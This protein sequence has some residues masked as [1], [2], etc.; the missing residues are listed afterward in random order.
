MIKN[1]KVLIL[2]MAKSGYEVAKLI[3]KGNNEIIVVFFSSFCYNK[4]KRCK[5]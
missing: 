2:G 3:S 1:K 4:T 5:E